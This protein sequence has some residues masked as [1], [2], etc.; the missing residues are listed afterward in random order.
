MEPITCGMTLAD[1]VAAYF[2]WLWSGR[3]WDINGLRTFFFER[4]L[5]KL[6]KKKSVDYQKYLMLLR[7]KQEILKKIHAD[8]WLPL[9]SIK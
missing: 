6:L 8:N 4:K 3:P 2:F 1:A 9:I 5:E 7:T